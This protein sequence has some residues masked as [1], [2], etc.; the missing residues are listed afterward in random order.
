MR[1]LKGIHFLILIIVILSI[2]FTMLGCND[3][4]NGN[5]D[6]QSNDKPVWRITYEGG[7]VVR[8]ENRAYNLE[9]EEIVLEFYF[10]CKLK[11]SEISNTNFDLDLYAKI[12]DDDVPRSIMSTESTTKNSV[13]I[14]VLED[15]CAENYPI[16]PAPNEHGEPI[17]VKI[18][19]EMFNLDKGVI[20]MW[21]QLKARM[22]DFLLY[23]EIID[24]IVYFKEGSLNYGEI[25]WY[26]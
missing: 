20:F 17:Y 2:V 13:V 10:G 18:P 26:D 19:K 1:K 15:F 16:I 14:H 11:R 21:T 22:V 6:V 12:F 3:E 24:T 4:N 23:Y 7:F 25:N 9:T 8:K 5:N